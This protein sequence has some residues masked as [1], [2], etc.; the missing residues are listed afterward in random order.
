[1]PNGTRASTSAAPVKSDAP[2]ERHSHRLGLRVLAMT[3]PGL[4]LSSLREL[5]DVD[6]T[7]PS[8]RQMNVSLQNEPLPS[9]VTIPEQQIQSEVSL[10]LPRRDPV[11]ALAIKPNLPWRAVGLCKTLGAHEEGKELLGRGIFLKCGRLSNL[12]TCRYVLVS[13]ISCDELWA[14]SIAGHNSAYTRRIVLSEQESM[15]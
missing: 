14:S 13:F 6:S 15:L 3:R 12:I 9:D 11:K 2:P 5:G 8:Y 10:A 1:M 4:F 7:T